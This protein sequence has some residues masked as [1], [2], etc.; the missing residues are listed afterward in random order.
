MDAI[1]ALPWIAAGLVVACTTGRCLASLDPVHGNFF[2]IITPTHL[3]LDGLFLGVV[4]AYYARFRPDW[5]TEHVGRHRNA[6]FASGLVLIAPMMVLDRGRGPYVMPIGPTL[7]YLGY[8][9]ILI[10]VVST[11]I[12]EGWPGK[13]LGSF[14]ARLIAF[15]GVYSYP[16]YLWHLDLAQAPLLWLLKTSAGREPSASRSAGVVFTSAYLALA[17]GVGIVMSLAI[18]RPTLALRDRL[19]PET[20]P[21]TRSR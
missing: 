14:P 2:H 19:F 8:G 6:L 4:L 3:R 13:I 9:S 18:E 17:T 11:P 1:P 10:A 20:S 16:I 12:G 7:L 15:I 21:L 5:I